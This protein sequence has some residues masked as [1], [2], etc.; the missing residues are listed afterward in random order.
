MCI[1][2]LYF[3]YTH[4]HPQ[5]IPKTSQDIISSIPRSIRVCISKSSPAASDALSTSATSAEGPVLCH[6]TC[7]PTGSP[8][9]VVG[10]C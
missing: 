8:R 4:T 7:P 5:D 2:K 1:P 6:V 3:I 9:R 10:V